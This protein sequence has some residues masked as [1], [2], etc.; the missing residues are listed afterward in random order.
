MSLTS[1]LELL[2]SHGKLRYKPYFLDILITSISEQIRSVADFR[3]YSRL[4]WSLFLLNVHDRNIIS[5]FVQLL[6]HTK[7][8]F[9]SFDPKYICHALVACSYFHVNDPSIYNTLILELVR[10]ENSIEPK[11]VKDLQLLEVM[12]RSKYV[13]G[14]ESVNLNASVLDFLARIRDKDVTE[15]VTS[16]PLQREIGRT[17]TFISH[18][19]IENVKIGPYFIDFL[20]PI[21]FDSHTY[22]DEDQLACQVPNL[23]SGMCPA[24]FP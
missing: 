12:I 6:I 2:Y 13:N 7:D 18:T 22:L 5:H 10:L 21:K 1:K 14:L 9:S 20:K 11:I 15:V 3:S 8:Y 23:R 17:G 24:K 19:L 16:S 4:L